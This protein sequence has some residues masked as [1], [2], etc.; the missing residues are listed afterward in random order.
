[1]NFIKNKDPLLLEKYLRTRIEELKA[2]SIVKNENLLPADLYISDKRCGYHKISKA[3]HISP[4]DVIKSDFAIVESSIYYPQK[5]N[6]LIPAIAF[7]AGNHSE[8]ILFIDGKEITG[9]ATGRWDDGKSV[10]L[11]E[12][13][14]G[15]HTISIH[16]E[17]DS[18]Y[19]EV[20]GKERTQIE[21]FNFQLIDKR[22]YEIHTNLAILLD[23]YSS[24]STR[25]TEKYVLREN[26]IQLYS[27][28]EIGDYHQIIKNYSQIM[29]FIESAFTN[30]KNNSPITIHM[31]GHA[32]IDIAWLWDIEKT[33]RKVVRT[34][35]NQ[36]NLIKKYPDMVF[37]QGQPWVYKYLK[38]NHK[39]L[40][41]QIKIYV[42]SGNIEPVGGIW[43]ECDMNITGLESIIRQ[44]LLGKNFIKKE[45]NIDCR[46]LWMPDV[47]GFTGALPQILKKS[48]I[49]TI[50]TSKISWNQHT[51]FPHDTFLW[52]SPDGSQVV[53]HFITLPV[54]G[55]DFH[56]YN[57]EA[58]LKNIYRSWDEYIDKNINQDLL[59]PYGYG[60]GGAGPKER[61]LDR[62]EIFK[63]NLPGF[64]NFKHSGIE[65]YG[66]VLLENIKNKGLPTWHKDLYL[67]LHRGTYS[68]QSNAKKYNAKLEYLLKSYEKLLVIHNKKDSQLQSL[69]EE[70]LVQQFH[71]ILP[72]TSV[73]KVYKDAMESYLSIE[74]ILQDKINSL[75][76]RKHSQES[77]EAIIF[78]PHSREYSGPVKYNGQYFYYKYLAPASLNNRKLKSIIFKESKG[79][80]LENDALKLTINTNNGSLSSV[81][82]KGL[83]IEYCRESLNQL[84]TYEDRPITS[85]KSAWLLEAY[86]HLKP[87]QKGLIVKESTIHSAESCS[88]CTLKGFIHNSP[89]T[90]DI[91]LF[92]GSKII[93]FDI[94]IDWQE[95][96]TVF[97]VEND[98][99]L[100]T[101]HVTYASQGCVIKKPNYSDTLEDKSQFE[102]PAQRWADMSE[103][104]YG[105]ALISDYKYSFS[106]QKNKLSMILL[107]ST[108]SP[109][110][111]ADQGTHA[112]QYALFPHSK[113]WIEADV[114]N[115][116][117]AFNEPPLVLP[118]KVEEDKHYYD[119]ADNN[120]IPHALILETIKNAEDGIGIIIRAHESK[121]SRGTVIITFK[122]LKKIKASICNI[123][124]EE[125]FALET[126]NNSINIDYKPFEIITI[127]IVGE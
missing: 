69:W 105:M 82:D 39:D 100:I 5:D 126:E 15:E 16:V 90:L 1:M 67:Q 17:T 70:Y 12:L 8:S 29:Q 112:I 121:G 7:R 68:S 22:I 62:I 91:M 107:R 54:E 52:T 118:C 84:N 125:L 63:K 55:G 3:S 96:N 85:K 50:V 41:K 123:L 4:F 42:K 75:F 25:E 38:E 28:I 30:N 92:D 101:D 86:H 81:Y 56:T 43:V 94:T 114:P 72:G 65:D 87:L 76:S 10:F 119:I 40:Y 97:K 110:P 47:F 33:K 71:D 73:N 26:I 109:D 18:S 99:N 89:V 61:M 108:V 66:R 14:V 79:S 60:D 49:D 44:I 2:L 45:F 111:T 27:L 113:T 77:R 19:G 122:T 98:L 78:N 21:Y 95:K 36:I 37:Q 57:G 13:S 80:I 117:R 46:V 6:S 103:S 104:S 35:L 24:L 31:T 20:R 34:F 11:Q 88:K 32:H 115:I 58:E 48:G 53:C 93:Y 106:A 59:I 102:N 83:N 64:Y 9:I 51:R 116:A 74:S 23:L 127:K 124:E 120:V